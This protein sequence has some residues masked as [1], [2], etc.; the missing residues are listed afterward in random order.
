MRIERS[1]VPFA[2]A[3]AVTGSVAVAQEQDVDV[4]STFEINANVTLASDY[5]FR[6]VSQTMED[7]AIQGGFELSHQSGVFAGVWG[8]TVDFADGGPDDDEAD[9]EVD[10]YAGYSFPIG[11]D[12]SFDGTIYR[13]VYPG[14]ASGFD[15]DYT[16]LTGC[17]HY[18]ESLSAT[19]AYSNDVF[20]TDRDGIYYR[21]AGS[22]PLP[23][24]MGLYATVGHYDLDDAYDESHADWSL[25]IERSFGPFT[26]GLTYYD[27]NSAGSR[28]FGD[29]ADGRMVLSFSADFGAWAPNAGAASFR[30]SVGACGATGVAEH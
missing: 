11:K 15:L 2:V 26:A 13:Y 21:L 8:S 6:G 23:Y 5:V 7:P 20:G 4:Q 3:L 27:T 16:E 18:R 25:G 12:F 29:T 17:L 9:L 30:T 14:T 28:I 1:A 19:V 10:L 22:V 24:D